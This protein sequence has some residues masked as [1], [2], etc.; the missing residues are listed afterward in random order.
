MVGFP[1]S[2]H[3]YIIIYLDMHMTNARIYTYESSKLKSLYATA[4]TYVALPSDEL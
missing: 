2:D 3:I 1:K 4:N